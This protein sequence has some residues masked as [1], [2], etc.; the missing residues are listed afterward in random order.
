M[1]RLIIIIVLALVWLVADSNHLLECGLQSALLYPFFHANLFHLLANSLA[2]YSIFTPKRTDNLRV[3]LIGYAISVVV[4]P[5]SFRP[6]I[7]ISNMLYAIIGMRT[8]PFSS[9]WWHTSPVRVFLCVTTVMVFV[10]QIAALTHVISFA[11][12]IA[13]A[14]LLRYI[15][16]HSHERR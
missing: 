5:F 3:L 15:K 6:L 13:V 2:V 1:Y 14:H 11:I 4:Y 12:G 7:G 10:P 9:Q 16:S 8:P